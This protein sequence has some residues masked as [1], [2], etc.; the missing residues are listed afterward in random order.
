MSTAQTTATWVFYMLLLLRRRL[1]IAWDDFDEI[2]K[3]YDLSEFLFEQYELLHYYD[4]D[5][6]I[7][8]ILRCIKDKG[9]D[10]CDY[11]GVA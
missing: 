10:V 3:R 5:Y 6:I 8:D 4:N 2:Q 1:G 9:G 11:Q 7:N